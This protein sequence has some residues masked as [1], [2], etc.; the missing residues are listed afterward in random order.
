M[1]FGDYYRS[2][3]KKIDD[4]L[5]SLVREKYPPNLY[6]PMKYALSQIGKRIRP[7]LLIFS[8]EA[9]GGSLRD[10]FDAAVAIEILHNFTLVHDDIMDDDQIRRGSKTIH[11]KWD[12]NVALLCGD[13][14]IALAYS[15]LLKSNEKCIKRITSIFSN[16]IVNV[17]EGQSLDKDFEVMKDVGMDE[18]IYMIKMK[19][20]VLMSISSEIGAILGG[21]S[22]KQISALRLYGMNVGIAFQIQDDLLDIISD[23]KTLGKQ[24]GS[25]LVQGKKTYP[26]ILL[27]QKADKKEKDYLKKMA[28]KVEI[29]KD[30]IFFIKEILNK[31]GIIDYTKKEVNKRIKKAASY[32]KNIGNNT[33]NLL[34]LTEMIEERKY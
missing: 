20:G 9:L 22:E 17:C 15:S 25:D 5:I 13:G 8:C 7:I 12:K 6:N 28:K 18:Y 31:Y 21:G 11:A 23:Q 1:E 10:C 3:Q 27:N 34:R 30:D 4:K 33:E 2:L 29:K 32:L 26:F 16:G 14:L 24:P 19:T